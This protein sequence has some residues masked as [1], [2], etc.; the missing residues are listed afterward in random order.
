MKP[1]TRVYAIILCLYKIWEGENIIYSV[2]KQSSSFLEP[3]EK[4]T[5]KA[6]RVIEVFYRLTEVVLMEIYTFVKICQMVYL[7]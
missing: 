4:D 3:Q 7:K 1:D 2:R 5:G 6:F